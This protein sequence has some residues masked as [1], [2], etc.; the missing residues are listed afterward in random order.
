MDNPT[1]VYPDYAAGVC[2][3]CGETADTI[4]H[5]LPRNWTGESHRKCVPVVPACR[6]CNSTLSDVFL[7]D[8]EE[9][10]DLVHSRYRKR[11]RR[12]LLMV[13]RTEEGLA[14]FGASLRLVIERMQDLHYWV[15]R[16]LS[17]P[18]KPNYDAEA[19]A[20]AWSLDKTFNA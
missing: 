13:A 14:E 20:A 4:D 1:Y 9:R 10:R 3:Y 15:Q 5:L 18:V 12:E 11:Y 19:W 7:P 17:W 2:V 8:V 6:E 16:R